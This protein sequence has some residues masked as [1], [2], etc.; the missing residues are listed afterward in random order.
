MRYI[1]YRKKT[2]PLIR[3]R[4]KSADVFLRSITKIDA[5]SISRTGDM[6]LVSC[7]ISGEKAFGDY[8]A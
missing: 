4:P 3:E 6:P 8:P 5:K 2:I 1:K 7:P